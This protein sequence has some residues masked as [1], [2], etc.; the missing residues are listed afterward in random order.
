MRMAWRGLG[1]LVCCSLGSLSLLS[2]CLG[3]R[4]GGEGATLGS[5]TTSGEATT[6][7][8]SLPRDALGTVLDATGV[9]EHTSRGYRLVSD[10]PPLLEATL[11][12]R[13]GAP[14]HLERADEEGFWAEVSAEGLED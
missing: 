11:P 5:S 10:A 2:G 4:S 9:M 7:L 3:K 14:L 8:E 1:A 13:T 6:I 12:D